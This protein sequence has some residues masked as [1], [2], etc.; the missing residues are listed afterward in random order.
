MT[1]NYFRQVYVLSGQKP[2]VVLLV[3]TQKLNHYDLIKIL[4][5][6][7]SKKPMAEDGRG[8]IVICLLVL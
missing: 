8:D 7:P 2:V 5:D 3:N 6:L 4:E 1:M